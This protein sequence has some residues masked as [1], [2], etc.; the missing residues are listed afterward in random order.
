MTAIAAQARARLDI[1]KVF[2]QTF[3]VLGRNIVPF[4]LAAVVMVIPSAINSFGQLNSLRGVAA[5]AVTAAQVA[6]HPLLYGLM[7]ILGIVVSL[8]VMGA[9]IVGAVRDLDE[10]PVDFAD[11]LKIGLRNVLGFVGLFILLVLGIAL[12]SVLLIV[13]GVILAMAWSVAIPAKVAEGINPI[14]AFGR[15]LALT[16]GHRWSIFLLSL[17]LWIAFAVAEFGLIGVAGG[18]GGAINFARVVTS[19][20]AVIVF[21]IFP[22]VVDLFGFTMGAALY[23]QL[24]TLRGGPGAQVIGEIFV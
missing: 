13:P 18:L 14:K 11:C 19:P 20:G 7:T 4:G 10:K 9:I 1:G 3:G 21:L 16:K 22:V 23:H 15:S 17:I 8:T 5:G 24:R 12:A 6:T 2:T